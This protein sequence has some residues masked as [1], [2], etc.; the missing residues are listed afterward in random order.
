[1]A[2]ITDLATKTWC[3]NGIMRS[4]YHRGSRAHTTLTTGVHWVTPL[5]RS[6]CHISEA[7]TGVLLD[8]AIN[9]IPGGYLP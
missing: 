2:G 3:S 4:L 6:H 8:T 1:M 5:V 7:V 9:V